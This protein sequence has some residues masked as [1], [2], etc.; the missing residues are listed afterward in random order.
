M[1]SLFIKRCPWIDHEAMTPRQKQQRG[2]WLLAALQNDRPQRAEALIRQG[3]DLSVRTPVGETALYPALA[4][5][6]S[7]LVPLLLE[8][9]ADPNV[10]GPGG[11]YPIHLTAEWGGEAAPS[12]LE[13]LLAHGA[14][15]DVRDDEGATAAF[16]AGKSASAETLHT[17]LRHGAN[18][19]DR[20]NELDT[21]LTF[22]CCWGMTER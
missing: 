8:C 4:P 14:R 20:N 22:A 12:L 16:L 17:L 11:T 1:C 3:A 10:P 13:A 7:P 21:A 2:R 5:N 15:I 9:G 6:L 19:S 18:V